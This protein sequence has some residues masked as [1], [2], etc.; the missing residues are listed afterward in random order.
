MQYLTR[1]RLT[2]AAALLRTQSA[3]LVEVALSIGYD[4]E[5]ALFLRYKY[6]LPARLFKMRLKLFRE[7]TLHSLFTLPSSSGFYRVD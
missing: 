2:K 5:V 4:S 7:G 3:T 6:R 1:V